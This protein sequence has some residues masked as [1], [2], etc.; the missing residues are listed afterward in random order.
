MM[1][2]QKQL[3]R[4]YDKYLDR[5]AKCTGIPKS[6]LKLPTDSTTLKETTEQLLNHGG[7]KMTYQ[8]L[9]SAIYDELHCYGDSAIAIAVLALIDKYFAINNIKPNIGKPASDVW[10]TN[11]GEK[12]PADAIIIAELN[13]GTIIPPDYACDLDMRPSDADYAIKRYIR[14]K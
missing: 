12:L 4:L 11:T 9:K 13:Y 8:E 1:L 6:Y 3:D 2:F 14:V 7:S 5:F 10:I